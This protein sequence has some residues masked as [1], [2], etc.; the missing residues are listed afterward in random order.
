[1]AGLQYTWKKSPKSSNGLLK[2]LDRVMCNMGF[3]DR[4]PNSNAIFLP[5][6]SLDHAPSI[7]NIPSIPGPKPK[8]FKFANFLA[9]KAEFIPAIKSAWEKQIPGYAMFS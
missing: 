3:L 2:T 1:M 9:S 6:V 7:L 8:P 4:F 5:F